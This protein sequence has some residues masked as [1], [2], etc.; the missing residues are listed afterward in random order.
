ML[1][2]IEIDGRPGVILDATC[3]YPTAGGQP[4]DLG[5]LNGVAVVDVIEHEGGLVHV[6]ASPLPPGPVHGALD[7]ARRFDHMQQH[8]GQHILS[9]AFEQA[10]GAATLSFHLGAET[11]T[12]DVDLPSCEAEGLAR[13]EEL[14]NRIVFENR[15]VQVREYA[16]EEIATLGLRKPP[17]V[18]GR[19]RVVTVEG[20]DASACGGTHVGSTG[21]VGCIHITRSERRRGGVRIEFLCGWRALR[22]YRARDAIVQH[23]AGELSVS[24]EDLPG[25]VARIQEEEQAQRRQAESLRRRLLVFEAPALASQAE[26][27]AGVRVVRRLL[28]G[29]DAQDARW[30]AANLA[31]SAGMVALLGVT[32]PGPQLCFARSS[33]VDLDMGAVLREALQAFG[34]RGGGRP[35]MA[36][37]GGVEAAQLPDV[38]ERALQQVRARLR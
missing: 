18:D 9:Q 12:I 30:L 15:T 29:F 11:S 23:V 17:A 38:L 1:A 8:S 5:T 25:A 20:F 19:V 16:A 32:E 21:E 13:V 28:E 37:G 26:D 10:L 31:E 7:W 3:F 27:L 14:A 33:D 36:Q 6:L 34:G 22:D 2:Q 4:H 35:H 24:V